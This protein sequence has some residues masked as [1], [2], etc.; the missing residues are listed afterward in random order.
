MNILFLGS[1]ELLARVRKQAIGQSWDIT[2]A[3]DPDHVLDF[4]GT[5]SFQAALFGLCEDGQVIRAAAQTAKRALNVPVT[6]GLVPLKHVES[7]CEWSQWGLDVLVPECGNDR[8]T[9]QQCDVILRFANGSPTESIT[10]GG[11]CFHYSEDS[12]S[13]NGQEIYLPRKKHKLLELLFLKRGRTVSKEMVFNHLYGWEE[14]P[15]PKIVDVFV[16]QIRRAL[17]EAG[18]EQDCIKTVWGQGY[19]VQ[20]KFG[21]EDHSLH[22]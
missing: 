2:R 4:E 7:F 21:T 16:C 18:L 19:Q 17:R 11:V 1:D 3:E 5:H 10:C 14:P 15:E 22:S 20:D 8:L 9:K 13:V 6:I 12:F